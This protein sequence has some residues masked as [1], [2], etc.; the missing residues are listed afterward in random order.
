MKQLEFL[1]WLTVKGSDCKKSCKHLSYDVNSSNESCEYGECGS[2][3]HLLF[4]LF[5]LLV[6]GDGICFVLKAEDGWKSLLSWGKGMSA[7]HCPFIVCFFNLFK[8]HQ[9]AKATCQL[10]GTEV[11]VG[12]G[13]RRWVG[14]SKSVWNLWPWNFLKL[15]QLEQPPCVAFVM[16]QRN[17]FIKRK[18]FSFFFSSL[19]FGYSSW[20]LLVPS[21]HFF[22]LKIILYFR[23]SKHL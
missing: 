18:I 8:R 9:N 7:T 23:C 21:L 4:L 19:V 1:W 17:W 10:Y 13:A 2:F 11:D 5:V 16:F 3:E 12:R 20:K 6:V 14:E 15:H 22:S